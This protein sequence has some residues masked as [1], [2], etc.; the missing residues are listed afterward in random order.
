MYG[1]GAS[2]RTDPAAKTLSPVPDFICSLNMPSDSALS[3]PRHAQIVSKKGR[4]FQN[5]ITFSH[6]TQSKT[7]KKV[8]LS[9][10]LQKMS[11]YDLSMSHWS[12]LKCTPPPHGEVGL[13]GA[14]CASDVRDQR[15]ILPGLH[16]WRLCK[17][18]FL[19]KIQG[20]VMINDG[21]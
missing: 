19:K 6:T 13:T 2:V 4:T 11:A 17:V 8:S 18:S 14:W 3:V 16:G 21:N 9:Q 10:K 1:Q 5:H 15:S 20:F 12:C 7:K